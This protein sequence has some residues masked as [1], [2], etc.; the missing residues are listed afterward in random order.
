MNIDDDVD[1][2]PVRRYRSSSAA[3]QPATGSTLNTAS[4]PIPN[5]AST[6][7]PST[8]I[9]NTAPTATTAAGRLNQAI[10]RAR[11]SLQRQGS[12]SS[13]LASELGRRFPFASPSQGEPS[14]TTKKK[15]ISAWKV[16]PCTLSGPNIHTVPKRGNLDRLC[17][18]GLGT[19][20]F[21]KED[22]LSIPTY[23]TPEELHFLIL[24]LY[25]T[26]SR[27][28]Y[29][30]CKAA[31]PGNSVILSLD[32]D[33]SRMKSHKDREFL[34]FFAPDRLKDAIGRKGRVYIRPLKRI[35]LA[36][37][38]PIPEYLVSF[39][40]YKKKLYLVVHS[41]MLTCRHIH[42]IIISTVTSVEHLFQCWV[43]TTTSMIV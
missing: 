25:P 21:T 33:D 20:W 35:D 30:F 26:L 1:F 27:I 29:E 31:G 11:L 16:V 41:T 7:I 10:R 40:G 38:A 3:S 8:P 22:P 17:K 37:L 12:S 14:R 19:L 39:Y 2:E 28:P 9:P 15:R 6:P 13:D 23:L 18:R 34:P 5:T 4:T 42:L 36:D 32:I 24:C 43:L